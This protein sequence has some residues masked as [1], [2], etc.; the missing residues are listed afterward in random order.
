MNAILIFIRYA[1]RLRTGRRVARIK[2]SPEFF[3]VGGTVVPWSSLSRISASRRTVFGRHEICLDIHAR[4]LRL[5]LALYEHQLGFDAFVAF[6]D[7]RLEF[8]FAWWE[9][10][11]VRE[12]LNG[13]APLYPFLNCV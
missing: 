12:G 1:M 11:P 8:P 13:P 2:V 4:H 6:A 10:L 7:Q 3:E 5:P 9:K